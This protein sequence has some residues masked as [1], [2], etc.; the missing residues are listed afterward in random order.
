MTKQFNVINSHEISISLFSR[1]QLLWKK[2]EI[3]SGYLISFNQEM[4][5]IQISVTARRHYLLHAVLLAP[6]SEMHDPETFEVIGYDRGVGRRH[7]KWWLDDFNKSTLGAPAVVCVSL[8]LLWLTR[9]V[10]SFVGDLFW[11]DERRRKKNSGHP[12]P[13]RQKQ[14][15]HLRS[16]WL[17]RIMTRLC[18]WKEGGAGKR[19]T[20]RQEDLHAPLALMRNLK[21]HSS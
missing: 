21:P 2:N 3:W 7:L 18:E 14:H 11:L 1:F 5:S 6:S 10:K 15:P 16:S 17:A 19:T 4:S 13:Q 20:P 9:V 12:Q 8:L